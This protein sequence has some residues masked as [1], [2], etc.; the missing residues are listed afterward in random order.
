MLPETGGLLRRGIEVVEQPS[1]TYRIQDGRI[2]GTVDGLEAVRQSV[3]CILNTERYD[4]L[5]YSWDYGVELK[6]LYGKPVGYVKSE[7]KKRVKEA[8]AQDDRILSVD[9]FEFEQKH[10]A[11]LVTF[12]VHTKQGDFQAGKEVQAGV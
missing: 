4:C 12:T 1:K 8:L 11:L 7:L 6:D 3:Y 2:Q 9:A 5:L 10:N